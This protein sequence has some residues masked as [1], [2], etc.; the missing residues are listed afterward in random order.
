[1]VE[2]GEVVL[3]GEQKVASDEV[4]IDMDA[5]TSTAAETCNK[6]IL[7]PWI[8]GQGNTTE[9]FDFIDQN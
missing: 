5:R 2:G 1:V 6:M 4:R 9:T 8:A 7:G 3:G